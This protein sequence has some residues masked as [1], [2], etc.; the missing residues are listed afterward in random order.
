M[1]WCVGRQLVRLALS[2]AKSRVYEL[3]TAATG[4]YVCLL[5]VRAAT[6]VSGWV[7]QGWAQ[8]SAK[9]KEWTV[10][11]IKAGVALF[12]LVGVIPLLFG[13]LLELVALMPVR[14]PLHQ[15]PVF[16][17]WQDWALG[18]MYTKISVALTFMG[19]EWWMKAAIERLYQDGVR[20]L[21][22]SFLIPKL[23]VPVCTTLGLALALP[24]V[25]AH[26]LAALVISD[27]VV[28]VG[29]QRRIYPFLLLLFAIGGV[30]ALQL[31]QFRKLYEHI[32]NDRYLVGRRLVNYNHPNSQASGN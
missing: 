14:V 31:R 24:Y 25:T 18:A 11:G 6:M 7:Q 26:S 20:N 32:K 29:I 8:L 9:I 12:L 30:A 2:E 15:S 27:P 17:P 21:N 19:P 22:L 28:L 23:V 10:T 5:A 13:F 16:F 1:Q 4:V 3:Y